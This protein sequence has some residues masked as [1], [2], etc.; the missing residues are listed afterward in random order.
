MIVVADPNEAEDRLRAGTLSCP[1]CAGRLRPYGHARTRTVRGLRGTRETARPRR[2]RCAGCRTTQVLLLATMTY[3][4]ADSTEVIGHALAAKAAGTGFRTIA[5]QLGRPVSTVRAWLRRARADHATW[6]YRQATEHCARVDREL[7]NHAA[8]LPTMLGRA[9]NLL[10]GAAL[11]HRERWRSD[12][13]PWA[14]MSCMS[15]GNLLGPP[16]KT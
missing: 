7:L 14:L 16:P 6:L 1:S 5:A 15:D 8:A 12:L 2:A 3:R 11:R 9:L 4:R 10:A 13:S